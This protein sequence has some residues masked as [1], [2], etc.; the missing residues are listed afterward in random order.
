MKASD[1]FVRA[2]EAEGVTRIFGVPGEENLDLLESLRTSSIE[3]VL[4]RH[5]QAA[6]FMAATYGRL[7]GHPGVCL[8][9]LGPGAT[10]FVT[11]TAYAHLGGMPVL[12]ITGQKPIK[13]S[14]QGRFQ[15]LDM[16]RI[17][18]P[19]TKM[20]RQIVNANNIPYLIREA[21]RVAAAE[22][23]GP[24]HLELPE[25]VAA[26]DVEREP[27]T[28]TRVSP[29]GASR[30]ALETAAQMI[31]AA[32]RPLLCIAAGANRERTLPAMQ[33]FVDKTGLYF[34]TTQMGKG[35]IDERHPRFLGTAALSEGDYVHCAVDRADLILIV[36]HDLSEKPPFFMRGSERRVIHLNYHPAGVDDVYFPQHEVIGCT[37]AN[38]S[39]LAELV[40]PS[41]AWDTSYFERVKKQLEDNV[42]RQTPPDAFPMSPQRVVDEVR[43]AV[44]SD[45]IVSLDNG[46][47]KI[48]FARGYRAH[49]PNTLLLDNALA[50]MGAGLPVAMGAKYVYPD[51]KIVAVTGDGGLMMNS[52]ELETAIRQRLDLA[53][54]VLRDD[55]YGMI[56]WKQGAMNFGDYGLQFGNPDF[57]RYAQS[58]GA[59]ATRVDRTGGLKEALLHAFEEGGVHL[60]DV[61]VD[62]S[63]NQ[64]VLIDELREKVCV[65]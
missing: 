13:K 30:S 54:V 3:L 17:M 20:S 2:L 60:I 47:Y 40:S 14:K 45:G 32:K 5:E 11:S 23:P 16:V 48:W 37:S 19:I 22:K 58:Y 27:F 6:G 57:V 21:F 29:P 33:S 59:S 28:V 49:Q 10:N 39:S 4:T 26:E 46:I 38:V 51:R 50:T 1:L 43:E 8:S 61:P 42:Y 18:E 53:V 56:R 15:I 31:A 34:F 24:V 25:D 55:A 36:G 44:P 52:Q 9:T 64:R 63:D 62:Y 65:L 12:F 7:T 35:T 41:S